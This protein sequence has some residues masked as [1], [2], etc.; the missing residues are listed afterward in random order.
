LAKIDAQIGARR[1]EAA[2]KPGSSRSQRPTP[3]PAQCELT[4]IKTPSYRRVQITV[5]L[6]QAG[7]AAMKSE[8]ESF[9]ALY[10]AN[11]LR[12]RR[13]LARMAGPQEAEDLTQVV[14]AKAAAALPRF[15]GDAE[16]STWLYRI[17][18]NVASD[19]LRSRS[20]YEAKV[21]TKLGKPQDENESKS[22]L[23]SGCTD[24]Q[25]SP[26]QELIR[27]EMNDCIRAVIGQLPDNHRTVL[28]LGELGRMSDGEVARVLGISPGNAKVRLHR[29]REQLKH[30]L[31]GRCDFYRNEDNEFACEPKPAACA[32]STRQSACSGAAKSD[33]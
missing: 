9:R 6:R 3:F 5:T 22:A 27:K 2:E 18:T 17:A 12:V 1:N 10:E 14:F 29:A 19:W 4:Y 11:H 24:A 23:T 21:T 26:E 32:T 31:T 20:A 33:G 28:L 30:A 8:T 15:R 7:V 16:A 25:T 13:L